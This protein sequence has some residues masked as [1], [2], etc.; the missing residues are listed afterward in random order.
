[1]YFFPLIEKIP[2]IWRFVIMFIQFFVELYCI[3]SQLSPLL[4]DNKVSYS[5]LPE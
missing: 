5:S 1:M 2:T 3:Y 4:R